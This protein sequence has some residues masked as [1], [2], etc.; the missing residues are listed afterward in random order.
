MNTENYH[1]MVCPNPEDDF[2]LHIEEMKQEVTT[3]KEKGF[4]MAA[5]EMELRTK[6]LELIRVIDKQLT[7]IKK[8][9]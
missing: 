8:L 7:E 3:L 2:N 5:K 1:W 9:T 6:E 4:L